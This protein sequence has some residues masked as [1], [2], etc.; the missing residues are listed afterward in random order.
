MPHDCPPLI[1]PSLLASDLSKLAE[2]SQRV[3]DA[4]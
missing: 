1:G 3:V 2:E 4:G